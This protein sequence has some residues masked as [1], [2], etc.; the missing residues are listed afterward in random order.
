MLKI[1]SSQQLK[2]DAKLSVYSIYS[3]DRLAVSKLVRWCEQ[4]QVLYSNFEVF[5]DGARVKVAC[6]DQDLTYM[7]LRF[8]S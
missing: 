4:N 1:L 3:E 5:A 6:R 7:L 8:G 2:R